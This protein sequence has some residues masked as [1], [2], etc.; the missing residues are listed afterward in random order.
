MRVIAGSARSLV[1]K[2]P[3]G[4]HTRPTLDKHKETL[5][6]CLQSD[7]VYSVFVDLFAGTGSIGIEALSRGA[8]R[9]YFVDNNN[10]AVKY[11]KDN[12]QTTKLVDKA[13]VLKEDVHTFLKTGL[14][15]HADIVFMDPP[16]KGGEYRSVFEI[17]KESEF[18]DEDTVIVAESGIEEDFGF[19]DELGFEIYKNKEYKTCKHVFIHKA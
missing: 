16:F 6:N 15:E 18:I 5:F 13:Y 1:L 3:K 9:A 17:L 7:I 19:L 14:K 8:A 11:I 2:A 10:E 12:L 4:D